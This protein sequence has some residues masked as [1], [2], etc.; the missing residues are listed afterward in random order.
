MQFGRP[1]FLRILAC[2][3]FGHDPDVPIAVGF[4]FGHLQSLSL[5]RRCGGSVFRRHSAGA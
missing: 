3:L 4:R 1:T 2:V 5:C